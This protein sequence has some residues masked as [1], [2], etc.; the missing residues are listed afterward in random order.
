MALTVLSIS[1]QVVYGNVGNSAA[2]PAI[3]SRGHEVLAVPT[4]VLS[5][6]PDLGVP[7]SLRVAAPD[8]AAI[9]GSLEDRGI[10]AGCSAV[11]TGYFPANDQIHGVARIIKRMRE[12]NPSLYVLVDPIIGDGDA[13]YVPLPVAEAIRDEL[14]PLANC[15]SPNRFELAWLS[16]Y[17]VT[18]VGEAVVAARSLGVSEVVATSIPVLPGG[19]A[20][21]VITSD[22]C[23]KEVSPLKPS[24]P[25]GTGDFLAG[26]YLAERFE[27]Q[28]QEA[29]RR[30]SAILQ[31]AI[32]RSVGS[33]VLN[34]TEK[35]Q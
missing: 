35:P 1:S 20:T 31:R 11:M 33:P 19:L 13:M 14:L 18:K 24:V 21:L 10:L 5:I 15:I 23:F 30:A 32:G 2:V 34:I 9:L 6:P 3:Q 12:R 17:R 27:H 4:I 8:L 7:I 28:P 25:H 22:D 29:L 26:L 16:G